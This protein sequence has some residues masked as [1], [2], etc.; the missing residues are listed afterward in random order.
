MDPQRWPTLV[1]RSCE[2]KR[3]HKIP[4]R[5]LSLASGGRGS[6]RDWNSA[7]I[8]GIRHVSAGLKVGRVHTGGGMWPEANKDTKTSVLQLQGTAF[9]QQRT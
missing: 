3:D 2:Y 5:E 9:C 1:P 4:F 7:G 8:R 6:E